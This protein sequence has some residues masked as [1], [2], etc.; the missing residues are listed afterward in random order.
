MRPSSSGSS[1]FTQRSSVDLPEPEAP[2]M[3]TT[4]CSATA[5]SIPR[6]TSFR[7]NDLWTSWSST[8]FMRAR[9]PCRRLRAISQSVKRVSGIVSNRNSKA[10][11]R[12]GV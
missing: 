5:R 10:V 3:Q 2:I 7:P 6:S 8:A 9:A 12:Y 1:R 11:A 4:S